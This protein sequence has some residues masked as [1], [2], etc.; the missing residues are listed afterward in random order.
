MS[1][2]KKE[3]VEGL[4]KNFILSPDCHDAET[5]LGGKGATTIYKKTSACYIA[6][7]NPGV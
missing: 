2:L 1:D 5:T 7:Y 6:N 3:V 4:K